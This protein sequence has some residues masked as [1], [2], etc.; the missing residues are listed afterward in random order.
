MK[1]STTISNVP[2]GAEALIVSGLEAKTILHISASDREMS[3]LISGLQFFAP[4]FDIIKF[5]AWDTLPY[6]RSSPNHIIVSQRVEALARLASG[7]DKPTVIATTI[8]AVL[9]RLPQSSVFKTS[10]LLLEK[11][12]QAK[13]EDI[14]KYLEKNGYE[15]VSKVIEPGEYAVRGSIIDLFPSGYDDAIRIDYFGDEIESIKTFDALTQISAGE[16]PRFQLLPASEIIFDKEH[17]EKFREN[18][19]KTFGAVTKVHAAVNPLYEA[20]TEGVKYPGMENWLPLFYDK[21]STIFDYLPDDTLIILDHLV[22]QAEDERFELIDDYYDARKNAQNADYKPLPVDAL[23]LTAEEFTAQVSAHNNL[24]LTAF[25]QEGN[26]SGFRKITKPGN[27]IEVLKTYLKPVAIA[28]SSNGGLDHLAGILKKHD[29]KSTKLN[30]WAEAKKLKNQIGLFVLPLEEGFETQDVIVISE[31]DIFGDRF[32]R[33]VKKKRNAENFMAEA[34]SFAVNDLIVHENHGIGQF[35]GLETLTVNGIAHDMV[36]LTY[37]DEARLFV[38]VEN[39]EVIT[40]YGGDA[41]NVRLD[42]LGGVFWQERKARLKARIKL[43]ADALLKVAAERALKTATPYVPNEGLYQEFTARFP[44]TETDDQL[45][46]IEDIVTDL[47]SGK[48]M[49]RL[50]CGDV[51]FGKT[52]VALRAAFTVANGSQVAVICPTT[53]LARQHFKNFSERFK[54]FPIE[55]R[56]LSRMV[57]AGEAKKTKALM[58]DGKVDI[59][60]G[61]HALLADDVKFKDLGLVIID[62]EQHFGVGQKEK[63]KKLRAEVHVLTLSA[64]PIPRSLQLSMAGIRDLSLIATPPVDRLAVRTFILPFDDLVIREAILRERN[65]GGRVFYVAPRLA[66]L[67]GLYKRIHKLV[68]EVKIGQAHGQLTPSELDKVMNEFFDGK[69]DV[70]LST[71]IVESGLDISNA[72]TIIIHRSD[73]FGLA[74]LYQLRGRVGRGKTRAY[75][76]L[77][78]EPRRIIGDNAL[79]RLEVIQGLDELGAGFSLASHDMDIRGFGNLLGDEQSGHIKEVGIELY[80]RMLKEAVERAKAEKGSQPTQG[81]SFTPDINIGASILI[82]EFYI[83]DLDLRLSLYKRAAALTDVNE[84]DAFRIE[85]TDRFGRPPQEVL[86]LLEVIKLKI[87]CRIACVMKIDVGP[88]AIVL[89]FHPSTKIS[90]EK[91]IDYVSKNSS[92]V[93]LR[94]DN[95][96]VFAKSETQEFEENKQTIEDVLNEIISL[97]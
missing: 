49:D 91:L 85:L 70:L 71:P 14:L 6:D 35:A 51:G 81:E 82:P 3:N 97:T 27:D 20:I 29:L 44:Y 64:T 87:M 95:K 54:G 68:P 63:L 75:A 69:F 30:S 55:V 42:K 11:G 66:D 10:A 22:E 33:T 32:I 34:A 62:E 5:P 8:N 39:I 93:K 17:R 89:Q 52:E 38:P 15:R 58:A 9:Q 46:A 25:A 59:V 72:N 56:Q 80:Q 47:A 53:L 73:M 60:I 65:R 4:N 48:P 18:Y 67:E 50:I 96:L 36:R 26:A 1:R 90:P 57:P 43:A 37:A 16:L 21:L 13:R 61:T 88:K 83:D 40:R 77:T 23:Y 19:R 79:K 28:A 94:P 86:H 78:L 12:G 41:E 7:I 2:H 24:C 92:R 31:Q 76:Y 45:R 74:Q 84:I